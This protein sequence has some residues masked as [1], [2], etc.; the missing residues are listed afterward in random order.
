[1]SEHQSGIDLQG[2]EESRAR[3]PPRKVSRLSSQQAQHK[4]DLDRSSQQAYRQRVKSRI[5]SL[6][7]ELA[8]MKAD[9]GSS[10]D[11]L[12]HKIQSLH[13]ENRELKMRLESIRRL[14]GINKNVSTSHQQ[15]PM[16]RC[17]G[18]SG[19]AP[20]AKAPVEAEVYNLAQVD[21][22]TL[23]EGPIY[24]SD[25]LSNSE[26]CMQSS[27][28]VSSVAVHHVT[29]L[30][31]NTTRARNDQAINSSPRSDAFLRNTRHHLPIKSPTQRQYAGGG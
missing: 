15:R 10:Q 25:T 5:K 14:V 20:I 3:R 8:R 11:T 6:E 19:Q 1:M 22:H 17:S 18:I 2:E 28:S 30:S 9:S 4:R 7:D 12:L 24:Q 29:S 26:N 21:N 27:Q 16:C 31:N 23:S 13:D